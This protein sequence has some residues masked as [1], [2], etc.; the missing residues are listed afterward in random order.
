MCPPPRETLQTISNTTGMLSD[1]L[2]GVVRAIHE[3]NAAAAAA[4]A[5]K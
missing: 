2:L 3:A 5:V 4:A 1:L